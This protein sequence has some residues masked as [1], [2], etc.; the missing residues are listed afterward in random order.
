MTE[1]Y[2]FLSYADDEALGV[3]YAEEGYEFDF[4]RENQSYKDWKPVTFTLRNGNYA[5]YQ[6]NDL[7]WLLCSERLRAIIQQYASPCDT[8]QWLSAKVI[9]PESRQRPY[10]ILHLPE[11]LDILHKRKTVFAG[12]VAIKPYLSLKAIGDHRVFRYRG[13]LFRPIVIADA[14]DAIVAA[15]CTGVYFYK[16]RVV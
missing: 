3:G 14:R 9:G 8:I 15:N 11:G 10:H 7:G 13:S 12:E 5:D 2:F 16:A 1:N 4:L 6:A